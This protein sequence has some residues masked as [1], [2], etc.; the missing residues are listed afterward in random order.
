M[1]GMGWSIRPFSG[2]DARSDRLAALGYDLDGLPASRE[3]PDAYAPEYLG[4]DYTPPPGIGIMHMVVEIDSGSEDARQLAQRARNWRAR[5]DQTTWPP[6]RTRSS[7]GSPTK[8]SRA[9]RRSGAT[10]RSTRSCPPSSP[11]SR[12]SAL[13]PVDSGTP[14]TRA[15]TCP[16]VAACRSGT[17]CMVTH[18]HCGRGIW[19]RRHYCLR[20]S[21]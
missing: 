10:G 14:G 5:W 18:A 12:R 21:S 3:R 20:S 16:T 19:R 15:G 4:A 17:T 1:R 9:W 11:L 6:P 2:S 13:A 8:A 7:S